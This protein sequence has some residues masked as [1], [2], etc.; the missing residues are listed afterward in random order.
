M[1]HE[2]IEAATPVDPRVLALYNEYAHGRLSRR[3]F[4]RKVSAL[5]IVGA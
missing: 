1:K 4:V 2:K 5:A 3:D